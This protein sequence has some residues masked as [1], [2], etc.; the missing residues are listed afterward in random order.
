MKGQVRH[1]KTA[2]AKAD[3]DAPLK[4]RFRTKRAA[5]SDEP[6]LSYAAT[7]DVAGL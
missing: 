7:H 4:R 6:V 2:P 5:F 1:G 3:R